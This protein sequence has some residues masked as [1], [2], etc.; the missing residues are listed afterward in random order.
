MCILDA[1]IAQEHRELVTAHARDHVLLTHPAA[2]QG[3]NA[4]EKFV[5]GGMATGV[6]DDLEPVQVDKAQYVLVAAA[7]PNGDGLGGCLFER[8]AIG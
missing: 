8:S 4:A 3:C 7:A 5:P 6:I 2:Q 1:T